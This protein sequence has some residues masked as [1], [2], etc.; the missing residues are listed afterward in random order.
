DPNKLDG[1]NRYI[2]ILDDI[3]NSE[4]FDLIKTYR[5]SRFS[6][7]DGDTDPFNFPVLGKENLTPIKEMLKSIKSFVDFATSIEGPGL[8]YDH[9]DD[10][11]NNFIVFHSKLWEE[12]RKRL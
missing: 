7:I 11:T 5:N 4:E 9:V 2:K 1:I 6:H 8:I 10:R 12:R 3:K